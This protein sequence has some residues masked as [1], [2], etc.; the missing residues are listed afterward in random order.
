MKI[1]TALFSGAGNTF[2]I[3]KSDH[4]NMSLEQKKHFSKNICARHA[5]DG[6]IYLTGDGS[7]QFTWDFFNNDGSEAEM[8]GNASRCVGCYIRHF[9]KDGNDHWRLKTAAGVVSIQALSNEEYQVIMTPLTLL[10]SVHGFFCNTGV[11]HL[12]VEL[13]KFEDFKAKRREAKGLR[14]H[15]DFSPPGTNV[16][17]ISFE[18]NL[19]LIKA[20]P[21]AI[22]NTRD[23]IPS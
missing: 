6:L 11:P 4:T 2:H 21:T 16:T 23:E 17:Y 3:V 10:S 14:E 12:V 19:K 1:E 7:E 13:K 20:P 18:E 9:L 15:K 22:S 5:A 8:C